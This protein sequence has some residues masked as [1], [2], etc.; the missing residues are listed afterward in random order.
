MLSGPVKKFLSCQGE[1][2]LIICYNV[3]DSAAEHAG[4]SRLAEGG[5]RKKS[6]LPALCAGTLNQKNKNERR[7]KPQRDRTAPTKWE[8]KT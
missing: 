2:T 3:R 4:R 7:R 5:E 1:K 6:G 8:D